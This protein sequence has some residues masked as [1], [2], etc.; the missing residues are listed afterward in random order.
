MIICR[1]L[2]SDS[3][4]S[5]GNTAQ[6]GKTTGISSA[7][8]SGKDIKIPKQNDSVNRQYQNKNKSK[9]GHKV[10]RKKRQQKTKQ[11]AKFRGGRS[12]AA[13]LF[14]CVL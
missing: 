4:H 10:N 12:A 7:L 5:T 6:K 9:N 1:L 3:V 13:V 11:A 14:L 2:Q 8:F